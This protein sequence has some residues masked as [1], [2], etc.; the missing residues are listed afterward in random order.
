MGI[1]VGTDGE[2]RVY[3][4]PLGPPLERRNDRA[5]SSRPRH[6]AH[7]TRTAFVTLYVALVQKL[8]AL[9]YHAW[10]QRVD[11]A[12][13]PPIADKVGL[14]ALGI[15]D[16]PPALTRVPRRTSEPPAQRSPSPSSV[17]ASSA[18]PWK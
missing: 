5:R 13:T 2:P 10:Y 6:G 14:P 4:R 12:P 11:G 9:R 15:C 3:Q 17:G 16:A 8:A 18:S 7:V 1:L